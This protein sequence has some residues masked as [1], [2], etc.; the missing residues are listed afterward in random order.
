MFFIYF[1]L[2]CLQLFFIVV[3]WHI[4]FRK[5]TGVNIMENFETSWTA[6][7]QAYIDEQ[8]ALNPE[9]QEIDLDNIDLDA[10]FAD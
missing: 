6:E 3:V 2:F 1:Y 4:E 8:I 10:F 9:C 5:L 7:D